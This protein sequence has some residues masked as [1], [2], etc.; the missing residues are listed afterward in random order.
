MPSRGGL[1]IVMMMIVRRDKLKLK[2]SLISYPLFTITAFQK[3]DVDD[4]ASP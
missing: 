2:T 4:C 3:L 1:M